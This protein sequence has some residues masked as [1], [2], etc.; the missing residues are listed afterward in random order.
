MAAFMDASGLAPSR[1]A[2]TLASRAAVA[3]ASFF[4]I[5]SQV[6]VVVEYTE[7]DLMETPSRNRCS[8][9]ALNIPTDW[10]H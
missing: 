7:R 5:G 8:F 9:G 6:L 10:R 1:C 4:P 3:L 2:C